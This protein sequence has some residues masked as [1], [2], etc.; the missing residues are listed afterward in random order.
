MTLAFTLLRSEGLAVT[1]R[2]LSPWPFATYKV[3]LVPAR[4][5]VQ[6]GG[7]TNSRSTVERAFDLARNGTCRTMDQLRAALKAERCDGV[8]GHL[9]S[10]SLAHQLRA[11][12]KA[13]DPS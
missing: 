9:A 3:R 10:P 8:E 4:N 12:M 1:G 7:V 13:K 11:I 2:A 5:A 6:S